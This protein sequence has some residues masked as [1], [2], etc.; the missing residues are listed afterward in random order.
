MEAKKTD[1][2]QPCRRDKR[3]LMEG[4]CKAFADIADNFDWDVYTADLAKEMAVKI[5]NKHMDNNSNEVG[6]YAVS[7]AKAVV[8]GLKRR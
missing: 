3:E 7:V 6:E 8:E 1:T 2:E 5:V 4:Y